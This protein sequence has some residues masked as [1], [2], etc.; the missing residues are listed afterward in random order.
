[1]KLAWKTLIYLTI[2]ACLGAQPKPIA[3]FNGTDLDG[4]YA[5][6]PERDTNPSVRDAFIVREGNLISLGTPRGHLITEKTF[7]N[8]RLDVEY[9]FVNEPGNCGVLV[10]A[11]KPRML[12]D[13]FPQSLEIQMNHQ[14]AGDFWCIGE[15]ITVPDMEER[16]GNREE[17][18]V[19]EGKKRRILNL[20]DGSEKSLGEWNHMRIECTDDE[21]KVW[22]NEDLVNHG[23]D[24]TATKGKIAIQAE[25]AEVAF[26][27]I[28]LTPMED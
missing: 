5:D 8:Y 11:S 2:W 20:T 12:Y 16:R 27:R 18:G 19:I 15:D 9:R 4:W 23:F 6:V 25:G 17:W 10:H 24:C 7:Q 28:E 13:M 21:I 1:M 22:V 3:L 26:R 14:H